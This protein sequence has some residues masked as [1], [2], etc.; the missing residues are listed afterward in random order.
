MIVRKHLDYRVVWKVGR[1][2]ILTLLILSVTVTILYRQFGHD[3]S[4]S[5]LPA[6]ILGIALSFLIGFRVN[7]A[8]E[9]WWEARKVWGAIVNDSRSLARQVNAFITHKWNPQMSDGQL[10]AVR[11][12]LVYGQ[13]GFVYALKHHLRRTEGSEETAPFF[14]PAVIGQLSHKTHLPNAILQLQA[15][16]MR[17]AFEHGHT[18]DFRHMQMDATLNRLCDSMGAAE[19]IKNTV[20]PRQYGYYSTL[21]SALYGYLLPFILV[22]EAGWL[23]I[24]F[25]VLIGFIF[26]AL[27]GIA[28]G[29]EN[30]FENS[31]NDTPLNAICRTI[32]INL[33]EMLDE[34]DLP[35]PVQPVNGF[36]L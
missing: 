25:T 34:R 10:A 32:E 28:R 18:E 22:Q 35:E 13:I 8:Y 24:P 33:R 19:R 17:R 15:D 2:R 7:S 1:V 27:D 20:F 14:D 29:I 11:K 31:F 5:T 12:E 21:F 26:F 6:S 36:L 16:R 4:I 3:V 23:T 30:P 9:R